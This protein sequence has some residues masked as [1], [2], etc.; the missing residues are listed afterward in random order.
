MNRAR[1]M[2]VAAAS[3]ASLA[4]VLA[5]AGHRDHA[6][7]AVRALLARQTVVH[8]ALPTAAPPAPAVAAPAVVPAASTP[9]AVAPA[10]ATPAPAPARSPVVRAPVQHATPARPAQAR[11]Q[12]GHLFVIALTGT[13]EA[14]LFGAGSP[15]PYLATQL[16]RQGTLLPGFRPLGAADLP[17]YIAAIGGQ[18]P[19]ALT[20]AECATFSEFPASAP[21][22]KA[23][24]VAGDGCV[25]PNSVITLADQLTASRRSW[26]A[27]VEDL[28]NGGAPAT[29]C[30]HPASDGPDDTLQ[31]RPGDQYATRHNPFVYFHSLLDLGDCIADD[32]PLDRLPSLLDGPA[33]KA[34]SYAFVAPNLCD[35]GTAAPCADG[36]AGG[37]AAADAFLSTWV[38]RIL[39]SAAYRR[40]GALLV[41]FLSSSAAAGGAA[42]PAT[43][44]L[45]LS[46]FARAG[47][48]VAGS[49]DPYSLLRS[50]EDLFALPPLAQ[51]RHARSFARAALPGAFKR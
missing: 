32:L 10:P 23:G 39:R 44:A 51:A 3:A 36:S 40:D 14:Q 34:P 49:Y 12:L 31:P 17:N 43:G 18:P 7:A 11:S 26:G 1:L 42:P 22:D 38:P 24:V 4:V 15:A 28:A 19:N 29:T 50:A 16:R 33:A 46:R 30:R 48:A 47:A 6:S 27:Y 5:E 20:N 37:P 21:V 2:A 13:T 41:V 8:A 9:T 35:D 25:Y 45:V